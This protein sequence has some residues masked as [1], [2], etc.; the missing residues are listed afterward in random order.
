MWLGKTRKATSSLLRDGW[1]KCVLVCEWLRRIHLCMDDNSWEL[2][3]MPA[4]YYFFNRKGVPDV[5]DA[6]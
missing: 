1:H 6:G 4:D 2:T 3:G 5:Q